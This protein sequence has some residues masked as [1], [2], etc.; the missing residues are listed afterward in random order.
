[1]KSSAAVLWYTL[2]RFAMLVAV[3]FVI[4]LLTPLR[5][6]WAIVLALLISGAI[7]LLVL[8]RQR[9]AVSTGVAN[10]F[11]RINA[12]IEESK[13]AE[14]FDEDEPAGEQDAED[15]QQQ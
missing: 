12:R 8:N 15:D 9:D 10:F 2:L 5:G 3:W 14:D 7:S 1:M 4:Q 6:V 11:G 13:T